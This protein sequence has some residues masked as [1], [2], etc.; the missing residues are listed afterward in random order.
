M[1]R[2]IQVVM[3]SLS[4]CPG[5]GFVNASAIPAASRSVLE[6]GGLALKGMQWHQVKAYA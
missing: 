1:R 3:V 5:R 4:G 2:S 6:R